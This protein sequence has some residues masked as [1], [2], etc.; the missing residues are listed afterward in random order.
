MK[1]YL[2]VIAVAVAPA[3]GKKNDVAVLEHEA[4]T[5]AKYYQPKVDE[6]DSR[7][8]AIFKRGSTIPGNLPGIEDV[9]KRLQEARDL[10]VKLRGVIGPGP[11]QKS[12]VEKQAEAAAKDRKLPELQ[13][14]VYDTET[15]IDHDMTVINDDL[16][17]VEAWIANYDRKTLAMN[18]PA[19]AGAQQGAQPAQPEPVN[20]PQTGQPPP[21][22][23][24]QGSAAAQQGSAAEQPKP[25]DKQ[26]TPKP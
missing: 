3:C 13:R 15:M 22:A 23:P 17:D 25:A 11:D 16:D 21:A 7:V 5:L 24:Q 14:L 6:L 2:L 12:A 19:P 9:G 20:T 8:Q 10:I 18:T 26:P 1:A 4:V